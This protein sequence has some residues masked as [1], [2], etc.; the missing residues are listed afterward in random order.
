MSRYV[1]SVNDCLVFFGQKGDRKSVI[2]GRVSIAL[3]LVGVIIA[4]GGLAG[5]SS[6]GAG[7]LGKGSL[8]SE[9]TIEQVLEERTDQW[10][11]IPGVEGTAIG[12]FQNKP[13]IM[14]LSSVAPRQ[15]RSKIPDTLEGYNIV[16]QQTGTFR[17]LEGQ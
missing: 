10:M 9:K 5:C 11:A 15:L 7:D 4:G 6:D 16:I 1:A 17:A 2:A 3:L 13:C 14:I 12:L 8:V